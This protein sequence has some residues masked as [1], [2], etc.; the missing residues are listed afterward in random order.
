MVKKVEED[1]QK[2]ADRKEAERHAEIMDML[3]AIKELLS[4]IRQN[5]FPGH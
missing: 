2:I 5:T 1:Q 4:Y 3:R